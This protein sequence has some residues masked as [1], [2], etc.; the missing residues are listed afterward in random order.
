MAELVLLA[1][2]ILV[3]YTFAGYPALVW[4]VAKVAPRP[5]SR[6]D[7]TPR[8]AI[9]VVAHNEAARIGR[10]IETCLALDYPA[11]RRR[12]VVASDG[13]DDGTAEIVAGYASRDVTPLAFPARRGKAA[14]LNDAVRACDEELILFTDARQRLD[15]MAARHLASNF[16]DPAVGAVSG[17]LV[18]ETEDMTAFGQGIDAYWRY[19]KFIRRQESAFGSVVGV[20]GAI[21]AVR[22]SAWREIPPDTIL[23]DVVIPMNVV[24]QGLRVVF[25]GRALAFDRPS[26]D[27]AQER[28]RKVRTLAGNYQMMAAHPIFLMPLRNPIVG[29]L[30]SHKLLRLAAPFLLASM[31]AANAVLALSSPAWLALLAAQVAGYAVGFAG[32]AWPAARGWKVAR[33]AGAFLALNG[34]AALALVEFLRNREVHL[35]TSKPGSAGH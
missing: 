28:A 26:S 35:W 3:A 4:F 29:Q 12:I 15:P 25:D 19:E 31:L 5:V 17:E 1:S 10:K 18:F 20:T 7:A 21:Y 9:I 6:G 13:S 23:D 11:D 16:A 14:C 8:L 30:V 33:R 22:R 24:M 27:P 32:L 2:F 34:Y